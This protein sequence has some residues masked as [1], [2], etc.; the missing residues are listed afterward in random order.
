[1]SCQHKVPAVRVCVTDIRK[2]I[3]I[4]CNTGFG[5]VFMNV[6]NNTQKVFISFNRLAL[7]LKN[8]LLCCV[9]KNLKTPPIF[10][11]IAYF[12]IECISFPF[13]GLFVFLCLQITKNGDTINI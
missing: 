6:P 2:F 5:M 12:A 8:K 11:I 1:M 10:F 3:K 13:F 7:C 4:T 9:I